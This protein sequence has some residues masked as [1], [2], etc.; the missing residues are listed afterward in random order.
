MEYEILIEASQF[1]G[2]LDIIYYVV[3]V[4]K[5]NYWIPVAKSNLIEKKSQKFDLLKVSSHKFPGE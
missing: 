5:D 2:K 3:E 1:T 4:Q